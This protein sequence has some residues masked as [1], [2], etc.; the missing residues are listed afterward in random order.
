MLRVQD[1]AFNVGRL[2]LVVG[3][4]Y[5]WG[6][7]ALLI[8]FGGR[9]GCGNSVGE[10]KEG[11]GERLWR[12]GSSEGRRPLR[13][14]PRWAPSCTRARLEHVVNRLGSGSAVLV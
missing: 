10:N 11:Q 1:I 6:E 3:V 5:S 14:A 7:D 9:C 2:G 13:W 12:W 8:L 4:S